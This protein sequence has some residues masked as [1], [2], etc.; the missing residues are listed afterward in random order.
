MRRYLKWVAPALAVAAVAAGG[1]AVSAA[2]VP[3]ASGQSPAQALIANLAGILHLSSDQMKSDLQQAADQTIDQMLSRGQITQQQ[4]D[5]MKKAVASG[6]F[7]GGFFGFGRQPGMMGGARTQVMRDAMSAGVTAAAGALGTTPDKLRSDLRSGKS[8]AQLEQ[9]AGVSDATLRTD[10][11]GAVK[12]VLDRAVAAGT[13]QQ[14]QEDQILNAIKNGRFPF[15]GPMG[16]HGR[17]GGPPGGGS[18]GQPGPAAFG[19]TSS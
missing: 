14:G 16:R 13:I 10:V 17:F 8:L 1:I 19:S 3:P 7:P 5:R 12:P 6:Q 11:A 15:G 9:A 2:S 4:A 18:G